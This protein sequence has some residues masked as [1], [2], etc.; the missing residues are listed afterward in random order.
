MNKSILGVICLV[1]LALDAAPVHS[2]SGHKRTQR[3]DETLRAVVEDEHGDPIQG[4]SIVGNGKAGI[5]YSDQAGRFVVSISE[6]TVVTLSAFGYK[7]KRLKL[8]TGDAFP[9]RIVL[10]RDPLFTA[11]HSCV[12]RNDG[13]YT[14]KFLEVGA[15]SSITREELGDYSDIIMTNGLQGRILGLQVRPTVN[16]LGNNNPEIYIRGL[17]AM[18]DN[19]AI[20]VIDGV[21]RSLDDLIVEEIERI[22]VMKDA[23]SKILYG[24]RAANG[25]L[26]VQTRRG[27]AH[28]RVYNVTAEMGI[29]RMTR[30]PEFLDSYSYATLYNEARANDGM[31]PFYTREQLLG[32]Y[33]SKGVNDLLYP[34]VDY[35]DEFLNANANYRKVA[36]DMSGGT[37]RVR[38]ALVVG[39]NGASGFEKSN[40]TPALNKFNLRGNLDFKVT[41]FVSVKADVAT[42]I[43]LRKL[44]QKNSSEVFSALNSH[45]PNE[46]PLVLMPDPSYPDLPRGYDDTVPAFGASLAQSNNLYADMMYG[47]YRD[48]RY[49]RS[50]MNLGLDFNLGM[51]TKG[52]TAGAYVSFDN[53]DYMQVS[54][55]KTYPTYAIDRYTDAS[56]QVE[57][58]YT[59]MRKSDVQTDQQRSSTSLQQLLGWNA[60]LAY[61]NTF[62]DHDVGVRLAYMYS[63]ISNQGVTQD[64]INSNVTLRLNYAYDDRYVIENDYAWMG[65]NRLAGR[66]RYFLSCALG[67]GWIVSQEAFLKNSRNVNF[68]KVK[69]SAGVLGYDRSTPYLL[70]TTSWQADGSFKFGPT[71]NGYS[72][73]L[74]TCLRISN[75]DLKWEKSVEYNIGLEGLFFR[76]RLYGELNWFQEQRKDIIGTVGASYGGYVG[77]FSCQDNMGEVHNRGI[78]VLLNWKDR[79]GDFSYS[80]GVNCVYTKN[81]VVKWNE[82]QHGEAYRYTVGKS[83]DD[84]QGLVSQGLFGR[85]IP[86]EGHPYQTFGDYRTGD[87][88]YQ[89]VNGDQ[90]ID[91][92]DV[93]SVGNSYPRMTFGLDLSFGCK[94]WKLDMHGYSEVDKNSWGTNAYYWNRGEGKYSEQA[95]DRYHETNN[96]A[97]RYPRLTTT[98]GENNFRNSTFWLLETGFFRM[99]NI[100]LSYT[101]STRN[102]TSSLKKVK[103][104]VR[105]NNLFVLSSVRELDPELLNAGVGNYPVTRTFTFGTTF[106][107]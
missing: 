52:L 82:V 13:G 36:F 75:P 62:G 31:M 51:L 98:S 11:D 15:T 92:R 66:N 64:N 105:G 50:Q 97:G 46:Y 95:L 20:V 55:S 104:F 44:G 101:F 22:E 8:S 71:N 4:V 39:Y 88:A 27:R 96:P 1:I 67:A 40:Y 45:R 24:P 76:N 2:Q 103:L 107:F 93:R 29:T 102:P 3:M 78:E 58:L 25:V 65:S 19:T 57:T 7:S 6:N 63:K 28:E 74:I 91:G 49:A 9:E 37:D 35:Y 30:L 17:H 87:I 10:E 43:E 99:K 84:M 73:N 16:G 69:A 21:E 23:T 18:S 83:T 59:Q 33:N 100:E 14:H 53:Y 42:R 26:Y 94:G 90:I 34:N 85:D 72:A 81:K 38:Y 48:E 5:V 32:Y 70:Y 79:V 47:G 68:L 54:L 86:M 89:D 80:V 56:G 60:F 61:D 41:D 77:D 106:V 12:N